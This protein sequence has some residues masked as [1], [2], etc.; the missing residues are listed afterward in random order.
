MTVWLGNYNI[1]TDSTPYDRQK[2]EIQTALQAYGTDNIGGITVGN[3][4]MLNYL[5][6]Y[7]DGSDDPNDAVGNQGE[8]SQGHFQCYGKA[9]TM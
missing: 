2:Q 5:N 4:W 3:E 6:T 9:Q 7:D 1:P 8:T